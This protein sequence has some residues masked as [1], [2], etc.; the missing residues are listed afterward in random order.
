MNRP[1]FALGLTGSIATGKSTALAAF[2]DLGH[3]TF[4]SDEAVHALYQGEAVGP[5]GDHFPEASD[6]TRIDRAILAAILVQH[7]ER[8]KELET[9]VHPMVR[10]KISQF[11]HSAETAG[12]ELIIIDI[13]LLFES[14]HD[15]DLDAVAV[16]FCDPEEQRRRALARPAMTP[17]KLDAILAKQMPQDEKKRRAD[18]LIDTN[19]PIAETGEQ[20][21]EIAAECLRRRS[22]LAKPDGS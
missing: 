12:A 21:A 7:P 1:P 13:P 2:A 10:D 14:A 6:G 4:S 22:A 20:V 17:E 16:T 18:F 3:P 9:I 5:V 8:L 11:R 15:Y 19:R